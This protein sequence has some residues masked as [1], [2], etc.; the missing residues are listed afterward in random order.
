MR[1]H[2]PGAIL[3]VVAVVVCP[4]FELKQNL[5]IFMNERRYQNQIL[6]GLDNFFIRIE[7]FSNL[8]VTVYLKKTP[9]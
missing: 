8:L 4:P 3:G 2:V 5:V 7:F 1:A 6:Y 9:Y